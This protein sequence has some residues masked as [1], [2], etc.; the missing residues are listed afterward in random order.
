MSTFHSE[1]GQQTGM[2]TVHHYKIH[3]HPHHELDPS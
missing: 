1:N 3:V 2:L